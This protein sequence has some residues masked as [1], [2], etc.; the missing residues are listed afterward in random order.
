MT[1]EFDPEAVKRAGEQYKQLGEWAAHRAKGLAGTLSECAGSAG[2]DNA[3]KDFCAKFDPAAK[4]AVQTGIG[5]ANGCYQVADLLYA[6]AV[7][8]Q[9]ADTAS[10]V[11][12]NT[13][14]AFAPGSKVTEQAPSV[15]SLLGGSGPPSWWESMKDYLQ[16]AM[17]PNGDVEKLRRLSSAF[18]GAS[19]QGL[20]NDLNRMEYPANGTSP[21]I[22]V[23]HQRSP[24]IPQAVAAM[25]EAR[26]ACKSLVDDW[27]AT[28]KCCADFAQ[29]IEDVR[30]AIG[31]EM[32][33]LLGTVAATEAVAAVLI[34]L[35]VGG[36]EVVSKMIDTE[37]LAATGA[38]IV[39]LI[40]EFRA[41][42]EL[43]AMPSVAASASMTRTLGTLGPLLSAQASLF[44]AEG[45]GLVTQAGMDLL[46]RPY[47][48]VGVRRDVEAAAAKT[49]D[50]KYYISATDDSVLIPVSKSYDTDVLGLPK[51]ADGKYYLGAGGIKYPVEPGYHLGHTFNNEWW[52]MRDQAIREGWTRQD[53]IEYAQNPRLYRI[54]DAPS[55]WAHK[56]EAPR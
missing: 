33:I 28:G 45:A 13:I 20:R 41:A 53:L 42:A 48:R 32:A 40:N 27:A 7:N 56:G 25:T 46:T 12:G 22:E 55:N 10:A 6:T 15:P 8:H 35:T 44:A 2:T 4:A 52:R 34:P 37:R 29:R 14:P 38:R 39:A 23:S 21:V 24:E 16:G 54:E 19:E 30:N 9:I 31:K 36:S 18:H 5:A 3:A 51:S 43:S 1:Q 26:D 17:W 47:I 11:N 50:G 49:G